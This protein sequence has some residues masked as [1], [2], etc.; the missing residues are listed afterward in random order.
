M[1]REHGMLTTLHV[2]VHTVTMKLMA[3]VASTSEILATLSDLI[4]MRRRCEAH[5]CM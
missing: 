5:A 3:Q 1:H 2:I 4:S